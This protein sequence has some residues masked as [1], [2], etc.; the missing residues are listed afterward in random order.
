MHPNGGWSPD[1]GQI[2]SFFVFLNSQLNKRN[3]HN[4]NAFDSGNFRLLGGPEILKCG[5]ISMNFLFVTSGRYVK[6]EQWKQQ[7]LKYSVPTKTQLS[8]FLGTPGEDYFK[9]NPKSLNFYFLVIWWGKYWLVE[10]EGWKYPP[11][12]LQKIGNIHPFHP[13]K[14]RLEHVVPWFFEYTQEVQRLNFAHW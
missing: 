6:V 11:S 4:K 3:W 14:N 9:G 1:F 5:L 2:N 7:N 10:K 8:N 13:K 12:E